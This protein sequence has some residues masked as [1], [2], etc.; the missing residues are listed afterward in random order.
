MGAV[1]LAL[2]AASGAWLEYGLL[3]RRLAGLIG[4]HGPEPRRMAR[5]VLAGGAALGAGFAAKVFL[6]FSLRPGLLNTLLA[7]GPMAWL[8]DPLAALA[9]GGV[10]GVAYLGTASLLGV[11]MPL[12]RKKQSRQLSTRPPCQRQNRYPRLF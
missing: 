3:R 10:F 9:T 6:G 1:G 8:L 11:G 4:D 5:I 7:S 12:R 2:G